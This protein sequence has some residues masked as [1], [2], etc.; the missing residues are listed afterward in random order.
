MAVAEAAVHTPRVAGFGAALLRLQ[1]RYSFAFALLLLAVLLLANFV[2][3]HGRFGWSDQLANFAPLAIAA[4]ASTPAI[5][6]GGGGFDLSISPL[7]FFTGEVFV[8]GLAPNGLGGA[9]S[10]PI[11]LA[12]GAAVG[13][14][15]GLLIIGLRVQPVVVT[16]S[17]YFI[18]IGADLTV[19]PAPQYLTGSW[20]RH[21]ATSVGPVPGAV[22]TLAFPILVWFGLGLTSYRR[23]L[24]A[25]GSNDATAFASGV[26]VAAVRLVAY[27][28]G[29]L[30]AGAGSLA[31]VGLTFSANASLSTTYTL[32]AIAAVALGGTSLWG[33]RGGLIGSMLGAACIY[34]LSNLLTTLQIDP[35]YLQ[36]VYG[37]MLIFAV[38]LSGVASRTRSRR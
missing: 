6:S 15:N 31:L 36:V 12:I 30:F 1:S 11:V 3:L 7:M 38:I 33:G 25:V 13:L 28:L 24:Y 9:E 29:G 16:L 21:L 2:E 32:L 34:L 22:L 19:A 26:N 27:A 10:V 8:V 18:L 35:S 20:V 4:M 23:T 14:V 17:M 37:A 5:I